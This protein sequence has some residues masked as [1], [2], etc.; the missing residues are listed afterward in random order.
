MVS[1][2]AAF[3]IK[4]KHQ[5]RTALKIEKTDKVLPAHMV[6]ENLEKLSDELD[7][8]A[9]LQEEVMNEFEKLEEY[10]KQEIEPEET[11]GIASE[12]L[13]RNRYRD[14]LPY[15]SNLVTLSRPSGKL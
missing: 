11:A 9:S 6:F 2:I 4:K 13:T 1:G 8:A 7:N 3:I 14:I 15:D 12:N 5:L 10:V